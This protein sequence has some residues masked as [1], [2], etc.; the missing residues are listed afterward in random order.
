MCCYNNF[1]D[2]FIYNSLN[3]IYII[4][5]YIAVCVCVCSACTYIYIY[6]TICTC[7]AWYT[8]VDLS[9]IQG[10]GS[11]SLRSGRQSTRRKLHPL[12]GHSSLGMGIAIQISHC[13]DLRR[14]LFRAHTMAGCS[15]A[16]FGSCH[17]HD[18]C[19]HCMQ[20]QYL[21]RQSRDKSSSGYKRYF[22]RNVH[23][24]HQEWLV[25]TPVTCPRQG[26]AGP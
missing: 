12:H 19:L 6:R 8:P 7:T 22:G 23:H 20:T 5:I 10:L 13:R 14:I 21:I 1:L 24:E 17:S 26:S 9:A 18:T 25:G 16:A 11:R 15:D 2:I 4:Y 3:D